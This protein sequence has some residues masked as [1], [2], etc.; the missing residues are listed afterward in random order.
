MRTRPVFAETVTFYKI[1]SEQFSNV[2]IPEVCMLAILFIYVKGCVVFSKTALP[3][4]MPVLGSNWKGRV[5]LIKLSNH[6]S[7]NY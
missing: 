4:V 3:N 7:R 6:S 2:V 1:W 5:A